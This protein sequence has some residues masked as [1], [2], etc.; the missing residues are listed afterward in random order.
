MHFGRCTFGNFDLHRIAD[1]AKTI[2][3]IE[4]LGGI[5]AA[6]EPGQRA[7]IVV[8]GDPPPAESRVM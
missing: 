7:F 1:Q 3:K 2:A 6:A 4:K 5:L 8:D